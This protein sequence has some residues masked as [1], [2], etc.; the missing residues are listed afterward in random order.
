MLKEKHIKKLTNNNNFHY[1]NNFFYIIIKVLV[2]ALFIYK[3]YYQTI[4]LFQVW[5]IKLD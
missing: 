2:I 3:V 4:D 5:I 1:F